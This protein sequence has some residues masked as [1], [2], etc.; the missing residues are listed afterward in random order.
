MDLYDIPNNRGVHILSY[1]YQEHRTHDEIVDFMR[2][3]FVKA[4]DF[5]SHILPAEQAAEGVRLIEERKAFKVIL[6]F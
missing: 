6:N 3:G 5:Y 1:P 2:R 4:S